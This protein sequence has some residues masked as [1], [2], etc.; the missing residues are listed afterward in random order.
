MFNVWVNDAARFFKGHHVHINARTE[1]DVTADLIMKKV[2]DSSGAK[3]ATSS[4]APVKPTAPV[5]PKPSVPQS[6]IGGS[7]YT[8]S[9]VANFP[10]PSNPSRPN[11]VPS[12]AAAPA[13]SGYSPSPAA[14]F[15]VPYTPPRPNAVVT[16]VPPRP[17]NVSA[18]SS[19][20][21]EEKERN[22]RIARQK[23]ER[24]EW[25]REQVQ[26]EERK[27]QE[28]RERDEQERKELE[29]REK[30][31]RQRNDKEK[32]KE[33]Q[34]I[35]Q[36]QEQLHREKQLEQE[37][38]NQ[39]EDETRRKLH[40]ESRLAEQSV[41]FQSVSNN[42]QTAVALYQYVAEE[43]NEIDMQEGEIITNIIQI[44]DGWWSGT[45]SSGKHGVFPANYVELQSPPPHA[46]IPVIEQKPIPP[47]PAPRVA[48]PAQGVTATALYDYEA[49]EDNEIS[50]NSDETVHNIEF[51][52]DDWWQGSVN[53]QVGLFPGNY[54]ALNQ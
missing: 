48:P 11:A 25:E 47:P 49:Q 16:T 26:V 45:N 37:R 10:T 34:I 18:P 2:R 39:R 50:F 5:V 22:E 23:A 38:I 28:R 30:E 20:Y 9:P 1:S 12:P 41:S 52:S 54:V 36:E 17:S 14:N 46:A 35:Q 4:V 6:S 43:A 44:D 42:T 13:R 24:E 19:H 33:N 15:S 40:E 7:S 31:L 8:P 51:V 53:G 29:Q 32:L 21:D 27:H 3:Y